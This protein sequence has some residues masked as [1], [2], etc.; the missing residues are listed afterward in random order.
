MIPKIWIWIS[1]LWIKLITL[2]IFSMWI[3]A[4]LALIIKDG[5]IASKKCE[6]HTINSLLWL[7]IHVAVEPDPK[8][9]LQDLNG[10]S[11]RLFTW[12]AKQYGMG[13][14]EWQSKVY[15]TFCTIRVVVR[16]PLLLYTLLSQH[17]GVRT[18]NQNVWL[19]LVCII[20]ILSF[21]FSDD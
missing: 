16:V 9:S 4:Q 3:I 17:V 10:T 8:T 15:P 2:F 12:Q 18:S 11:N 20:I 13:P 5:V 14:A 21:L 7:I 19:R 1:G 6:S